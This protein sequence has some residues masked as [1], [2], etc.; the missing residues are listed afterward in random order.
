MSHELFRTARVD[1]TLNPRRIANEEIRDLAHVY[2]RQVVA[3]S[4][5]R[6][7]VIVQQM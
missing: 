7:C 6:G 2:Y 3:A 1:P 4:L 5:L